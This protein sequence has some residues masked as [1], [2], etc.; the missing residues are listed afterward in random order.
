[1]KWVDYRWVGEWVVLG[2]F[3]ILLPLHFSFIYSTPTLH[4]FYFSKPLKPLT[5][6]LKPQPTPRKALSLLPR[7]IPGH[8]YTTRISPNHLN[9]FINLGNLLVKNQ[10]RLLEADQ[11]LKTAISMRSLIG[12]SQLFIIMN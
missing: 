10:S 12:W 5:H 2:L 7:M 6:P 8:N 4:P 9:V 3:F 1:M 11:L